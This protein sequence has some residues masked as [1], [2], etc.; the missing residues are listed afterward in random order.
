M[1]TTQFSDIQDALLFVS[2]ARCG[3]NSAILCKDTGEIYYHSEDGAID[4]I[5]D[6]EFDCDD[7]IEIPHKID[8]GLGRELVYEFVDKYLANEINRVQTIFQSRG[9]YSRFRDFLEQRKMLQR[10]YDFE[11]L[12]EEEV[13]RQWCKEN[14]IHLAKEDL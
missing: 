13:L 12:R 6:E 5:D 8:L 2:S 4:E 10:W 9:A 3:M 1:K 7:F 11:S 14:E